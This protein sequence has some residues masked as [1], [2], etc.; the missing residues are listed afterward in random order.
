MADNDR[1]RRFRSTPDRSFNAHPGSLFYDPDTSAPTSAHAAPRRR[2]DAQATQDVIDVAAFI[3]KVETERSHGRP[4]PTPQP[5]QNV[6]GA[7]RGS[8]AA[9]TTIQILAAAATARHFGPQSA[10]ARKWE[11]L[12]QDNAGRLEA[13]K[14]QQYRQEQARPE[15]GV[16]AGQLQQRTAERAQADAEND[17]RVFDAAAALA[18]SY[19]AVKSLPPFDKLAELSREHV[20]GAVTNPASIDVLESGVTPRGEQGRETEFGGG[21]DLGKDTVDT[22]PPTFTESTENADVSGELE[23]VVQ[24]PQ[25]N[26]TDLNNIGSALH[27]AGR[28]VATAVGPVQGDDEVAPPLSPVDLSQLSQELLDAV[29]AAM[30]GHPRSVAELLNIE[31]EPDRSNGTA[32]IPDTAIERAQEATL[33]Y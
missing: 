16:A 4:A 28:G 25:K 7:F 10:N 11:K 2:P 1:K 31:R 13:A 8:P 19:V 32:F 20:T 14:A 27:S 24:P 21:V 12:A 18:L 6:L 15:V 29:G 30:S 22:E 3:G 5:M 23:Q 17:R 26:G 9:Q 33:G